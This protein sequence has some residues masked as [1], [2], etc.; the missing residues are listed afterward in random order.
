MK[1]AQLRGVTTTTQNNNITE[2]TNCVRE[3]NCRNKH[4][5]PL[6]NKCLTKDIVYMATVESEG[7]EYKYIGATA[8]E[9]Q[10]A[11]AEPHS[12][13]QKN[14]YETLYILS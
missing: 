2:T 1:R 3:C 7:L 5:C 12:L 13:I 4:Q 8:C 14:K 6:Q 9:F 11:L 10:I